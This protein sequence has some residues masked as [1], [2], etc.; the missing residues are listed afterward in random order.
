MQIPLQSPKK[1]IFLTVCFLAAALYLASSAAD[2]IA[3]HISERP[4]LT[5][6]Q[7]AT[8]I[9]PGN[10]ENWFRVGRYQLLLNHSPEEAA[11]ALRMATSLN[12]HKARYWLELASA[13]QAEGDQSAQTL[14]LQHALQVEPRTPTVAWDAGNLYMVMGDSEKAFQ[15]FRIVLRDDPHMAPA[16]LPMC[17]RLSRDTDSYHLPPDP[18]VYFALLDFLVARQETAEAEKVWNRLALLRQPLERTRAFDF[19][20]FLIAQQEID[21]AATVWKQCA[22]LCGLQ[23]YQP[24]ADNLIINGDFSLDVL[25]NGFDWLYTKSQ[26]VSLAVDPLQTHAGHRSLLID[27][28]ARTLEEAGIKQLIPVRQGTSYEFSAYFKVENLQG[29]GGPRFALS[30]AYANSTIYAS[31]ALTSS[32]AWKQ[33]QG[34]FTTGP[35]TKLLAL[36]VQRVPV[37]DAIRGK[38]WISDISLSPVH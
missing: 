13:R 19:I 1:Y 12:P 30:D 15:E 10:A 35:D 34:S 24:S 33:V 37:G 9:V 38:L 25:N 7:R 4:T 28:D 23:A 27:V 36:Q 8:R 18:Q 26:D 5:N 3:L 11:N 14:A 21:Q 22:S 20:R 6:L 17:W 2:F 31:D 29:A 16:V 32:E